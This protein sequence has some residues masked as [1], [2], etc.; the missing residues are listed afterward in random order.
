MTI[1]VGI[2]GL[3]GHGK[4]TFANMLVEEL[5]VQDRTADTYHM[6]DPLKE[7]TKYVFDMGDED[8]NTQA[9]KKGKHRNAYGLTTRQVLQKMGT[10]AFRD[11]FN[12]EIWVHVAERQVQARSH[13]DFVFIPDI[14]FADEAAWINSKG[15]L[16]NVFNPNAEEITQ[17]VPGAIEPLHRSEQ[18]HGQPS[19]IYILNDTDLD[20]LRHKAKLVVPQL[21]A[22]LNK[23]NKLIAEASKSAITSQFA[24]GNPTY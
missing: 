7:I 2:G 8:V 18:G 13:N 19:H 21:I 9:G 4:D 23:A 22:A 6:A 20:A 5:K 10:E 17:A 11:V 15:I 14:R 1:I 16:I 12:Q 3:A 24:H